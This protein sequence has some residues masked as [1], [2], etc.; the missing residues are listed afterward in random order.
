M[1]NTATPHDDDADFALIERDLEA[2]IGRDSFVDFVERFF[3]VVTGVP[4][5]PNIATTAII[6]A[7]QAL[8]TD[9]S[10]GSWWRFHRAPGRARCSV[11]SQPGASHVTRR[12]DPSTHVTRSASPRPS[13]A[14]CAG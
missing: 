10:R 11:S 14:A 3:S 1:P 7:L 12:G 13:H 8:P 9:A 6:T 2:S 5:V 4:F